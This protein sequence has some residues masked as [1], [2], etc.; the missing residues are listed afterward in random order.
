MADW[1]R[2]ADL[3]TGSTLLLPCRLT[4]KSAA[5]VTLDM[6]AA[7][8]TATGTV[9]I[10]EPG[11]AVTGTYTADPR[12]QPV[13]AVAITMAVGDQMQNQKTGEVVIVQ[14]VG[15]PPNGSRWSNAPGGTP[16]FTGE[17]W[18]PYRP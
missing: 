7:D 9:Q 18:V 4:A 6:I 11:G 1:M 8:R 15:L 14:A 10:A 5:G 2:L 13:H 3:P 17:G 16:S 12:E